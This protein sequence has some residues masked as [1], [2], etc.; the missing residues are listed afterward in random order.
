M[1]VETGEEVT[2]NRQGCLLQEAKVR[3]SGKRRPLRK[4]LH[5]TW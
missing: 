3:E 2:R 1:N 5:L 4:G